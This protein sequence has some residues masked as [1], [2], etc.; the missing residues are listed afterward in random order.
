M[1]EWTF[2]SE[3]TLG[4]SPVSSRG[5]DGVVSPLEV[6]QDDESLVPLVLVESTGSTGS[7]GSTESTCFTD[8]TEPMDS[9]GPVVLIDINKESKPYIDTPKRKPPPYSTYINIFLTGSSFI[10][11]WFAYQHFYA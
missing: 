9:T 2:V 3:K 10:V 6:Y 4:E 8:P 1:D 11:F 7:T 5:S